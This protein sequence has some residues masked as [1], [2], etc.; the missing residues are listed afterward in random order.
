M[1]SRQHGFKI[2]GIGKTGMRTTRPQ[3]PKVLP[4]CPKH[5]LKHTQQNPLKNLSERMVTWLTNAIRTIDLNAHAILQGQCRGFATLAVDLL[6]HEQIRGLVEVDLGSRRANQPPQHRG[7]RRAY[8]LVTFM[9]ILYIY[10]TSPTA[11]FRMVVVTTDIIEHNLFMDSIS[12][13]AA[14]LFL[15]FHT[16]ATLAQLRLC[17]DLKSLR[18][19]KIPSG[20]Q[21]TPT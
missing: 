12:T 1:L 20:F 9:L 13:N 11:F 15:F 2:L 21:Q 19:I 8:I 17:E 3:D 6:P 14:Q 7:E 16:C 5:I 10:P 18:W 4:K